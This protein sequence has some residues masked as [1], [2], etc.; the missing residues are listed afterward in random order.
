MTMLIEPMCHKRGCQHFL[1]H[2]RIDG[3][4]ETLKHVCEAYPMG[5]PNEIQSGEDLHL[6]VRED[7]FGGYVFEPPL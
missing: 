5:I 2:R 1:G 6:E 7:Q 4:D 3:T